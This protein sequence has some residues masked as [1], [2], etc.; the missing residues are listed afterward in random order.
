MRPT[1]SAPASKAAP[2]FAIH[3]DNRNAAYLVRRRDSRIVAALPRM[4]AYVLA[5]RLSYTLEEIRSFAESAG[6]AVQQVADRVE[7]RFR[8]ILEAGI[9]LPFPAER[10]L[11]VAVA[12]HANGLRDLP[13][14]RVLHW[15]VTRYCPRKC[16]YCY[17]E[18]LPG[19]QPL[20]SV[21]SRQELRRIFEEAAELGA[22]HFVVSGSEPFLRPDLPEIMGDAIACGITPFIT[23]K[24]PI[25]PDLAQRLAHAG[26][27]HLS[28]S[29]DTVSP[30]LSLEIIGSRTYPAQVRASAANLQNAG[31]R[32]SIQAVAAR[33]NAGALEDVARFAAELNAV[34]LQIVPFEP[35]RL[36]LTESR[37]HDMLLPDPDFVQK[38][39]GRLSCAYPSLR[40]EVFNKAQEASGYHCDIGMTKLFFLPDGTVHRCYKLAH[41]D[42]LRGRNLRQT[43]V[44]EAWHDP[45]FQPV[46]SPSRDSYQGSN[47]HGCGEFHTCHS[48][49]RCIFEAAAN[50]G[51][52]YAPDRACGG[53][54]P[55][56]HEP[57]VSI[58]P[59]L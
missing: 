26:L 27:R 46:I 14:P 30:D 39:V 4:E 29:L 31:I 23:T 19:G 49:G 22:E 32:F 42:S 5:L 52:Y 57:L 21:I 11:T 12:P 44:A 47:C 15:T 43:S 8:R 24:H 13:G 1:H 34:V 6:G 56:A 53:P 58:S 10:L 20:D 40:I 55:V 38:E 59:A 3:I 51:R 37:N 9:H 7:H 50:W 18:P 25:G 2:P 33:Q 48:E 54:F 35:V 36:P 45:Q 17:A 41:D 28:I 16:I